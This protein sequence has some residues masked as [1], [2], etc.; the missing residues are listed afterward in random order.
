MDT[1]GPSR[2]AH[3]WCMSCLEVRAQGQSQRGLPVQEDAQLTYGLRVD[4]Y[5]DG[6]STQGSLAPS[7]DA[8]TNRQALLE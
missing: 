6:A 4:P 5:G 1:Q 7:M 3:A 8:A 2:K